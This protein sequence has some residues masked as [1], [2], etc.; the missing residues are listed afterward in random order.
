MTKLPQVSPNI[1]LAITEASGKQ[2][3]ASAP[4]GGKKKEASPRSGATEHQSIRPA[5]TAI[6]HARGGNKGK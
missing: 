4:G 2:K 3:E 6:A 1:L 5:R